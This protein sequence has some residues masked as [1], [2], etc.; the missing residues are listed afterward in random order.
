MKD[1]SPTAKVVAG[2]LMLQPRSGY[3][4]KQFVDRSTRFFWSA[5]YGQIYPELRRLEEAGLVEGVAEATGD[6][7]RTTYR[8]TPEGKKAVRAWLREP[9][10]TYELR[11]EGM[12]K[13][14]LSDALPPA[15]RA[16]RLLDMRDQHLEKLAQLREV[17]A[18]LPAESRQGS[19]YLILRYGIESSEWTAAWCERAARELDRGSAGRR[20]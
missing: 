16:Q 19:A 2:L 1:L 20:K 4:I 7:A 11:H 8:L 6:R 14:F 17:E 12:L 3:E 15:D 5:S 18:G 9:P 13:A 10:E